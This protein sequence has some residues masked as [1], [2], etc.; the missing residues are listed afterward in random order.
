MLKILNMV[1][2]VNADTTK[3]HI[4]AEISV[5]NSSELVTEVDNYVFEEGSIGWDISEGDFYGLTGGSWVKQ[6]S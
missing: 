6:N 3:E 4:R 2:E 1:K 5:S